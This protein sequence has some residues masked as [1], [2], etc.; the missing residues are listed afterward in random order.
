MVTADSLGSFI[1]SVPDFPKKGIMFRDITTLLK[2]AEAFRAA[3]DALAVRYRNAGV[4]KIVSIESRGFIFGSA[5][6]YA[7]GTGFVPV[8]KPGKL[9]SDVVRESYQLEYGSDTLELHRDAVVPGERVLLIDDL[10]ATGGTMEAAA[11]LVERLGGKIAGMAFLIELTFLKGR[12][13]LSRY[14]VTS[15]ITYDGE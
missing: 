13:R 9:P 5:L 7:L 6:A 4:A 2:D 3:I 10:L 1:R 8:R 14:D 15:L 12:L 11:A